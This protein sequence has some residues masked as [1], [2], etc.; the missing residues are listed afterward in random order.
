MRPVL[1]LK[2]ASQPKVQPTMK[3]LLLAAAACVFASTA[4]ATPGDQSYPLY[5]RPGSVNPLGYCQIT[6]TPSV[7]NSFTAGCSSGIPKGAT[8]AFVCSES[9]DSVRWRD[10]INTPC[11]TGIPTSTIGQLFGAGSVAVPAC[12]AVSTNLASVR[13][14][15][16]ATG[17]ILDV[18]FYQ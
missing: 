18:S 2:V 8:Y 17:A 12:S 13:L 15:A 4:F 10:D 3:R 14:I 6:V 1:D 7:V 16:V 11:N 9:A 5:M